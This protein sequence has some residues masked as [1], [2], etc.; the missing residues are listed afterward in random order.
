MSHPDVTVG[1]IANVYVHG[2]IRKG[3]NIFGGVQCVVVEDDGIFEVC[4]RLVTE[5][6]TTITKRMR[7]AGN[8]VLIVTGQL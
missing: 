8:R 6:T 3:K 7:G 5:G 1:G 4:C 2:A